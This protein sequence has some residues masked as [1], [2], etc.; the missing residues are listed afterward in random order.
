MRNQILAASL[1][2][3]L[4]GMA[5]SASAIQK[6]D[7]VEFTANIQ[8]Q[9]QIGGGTFLYNLEGTLTRATGGFHIWVLCNQETPYTVGMGDGQGRG[10]NP[11]SSELRTLASAA[12]NGYNLPYSLYMGAGTAFPWNDLTT[13]QTYSGLGTGQYEMIPGTIEFFEISR[14]PSGD[15]ND[16]VVATIDYAGFV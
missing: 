1:G 12:G 15:Y 7:N 6:S 10:L 11:L 2:A 13:M 8:A 4:L 5:G 14:H 9:C 16:V 3:V